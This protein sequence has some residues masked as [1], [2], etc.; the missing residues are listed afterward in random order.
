MP[1]DDFELSTDFGF[2][3]ELS[4][5]ATVSGDAFTRQHVTLTVLDTVADERGRRRTE[6]LLTDLRDELERR[7]EA[8]PSVDRVGSITFDRSAPP[9]TLKGSVEAAGIKAPFEVPL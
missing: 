5:Y 9:K 8:N 3:T 2:G 1:P 4:R 6:E 7:L